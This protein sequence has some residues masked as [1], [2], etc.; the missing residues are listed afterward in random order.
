MSIAVTA[1]INNHYK[2]VGVVTPEY[3]LLPEYIFNEL[4]KRQIFIH[5]KINSLSITT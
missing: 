3:A 4:E 5:E 1:I 2:G